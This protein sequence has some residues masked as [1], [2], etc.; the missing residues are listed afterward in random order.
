[1][2]VITKSLK[3]TRIKQK[4]KQQKR[5]LKGEKFS[6][7]SVNIKCFLSTLCLGKKEFKC[8]TILMNM[9]FHVFQLHP[10]WFVQ[11]SANANRFV[12]F[13]FFL[14]QEAT[15]RILSLHGYKNS[16][17]LRIT[18]CVHVLKHNVLVFLSSECSTQL[19]TP[20]HSIRGQAMIFYLY[21]FLSLFT[22]A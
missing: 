4:K 14:W 16:N 13:F 12:L 18:L 6:S 7:K 1:M 17:M 3:K 5:E 20:N 15:A 2:I 8:R 10:T 22:D 21:V 11:L 19:L 9:L